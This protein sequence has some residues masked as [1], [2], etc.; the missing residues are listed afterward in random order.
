M[1]DPVRALFIRLA[2]RAKGDPNYMPDPALTGRALLWLLLGRGWAY[3]RGL[4]W[5]PRLRSAGAP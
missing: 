5:R 2:Q 1:A 4:W 3:W